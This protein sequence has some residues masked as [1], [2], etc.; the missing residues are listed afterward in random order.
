MNLT[1]LRAIR[2][3]QGP[4]N[5]KEVQSFVGFINFYLKFANNHASLISRHIDFI[6]KDKK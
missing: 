4:W 3:F 5:N 2:D 6:K 1:K